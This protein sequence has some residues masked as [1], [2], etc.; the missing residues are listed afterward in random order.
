MSL[1]AQA[2]T[3]DVY[4]G[5]VFPPAMIAGEVW[6]IHFGFP[7]IVSTNIAAL[8]KKLLSSGEEFHGWKFLSA[9]VVTAPEGGTPRPEK[10][11]ALTVEITRTQQVSIVQGNFSFL[12]ALLKNAQLILSLAGL[13]IFIYAIIRVKKAIDVVIPG[14]KEISATAW[15]LWV[16]IGIL[17]VFMSTRKKR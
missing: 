14:G 16:G 3:S 9:T 2:A 8:T 5:G 15:V 10:T 12:L 11:L 4:W 17:L 13:A 1:P 6:E 7:E